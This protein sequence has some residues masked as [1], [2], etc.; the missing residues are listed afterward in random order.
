MSCKKVVRCLAVAGCVAAAGMAWAG[1]TRVDRGDA[2]DK[3]GATA[4]AQS[5][6]LRDALALI[7]ASLP[8]STALS[9]S[10]SGFLAAHDGASGDVVGLAFAEEVYRV[11]LFSRSQVIKSHI[12]LVQADLS[13]DAVV[14]RVRGETG[15][16]FI[17]TIL[18]RDHIAPIDGPGTCGAT[19][20]L[21]MGPG[22]VGDSRVFVTGVTGEDLEASLDR[23]FEVASPFLTVAEGTQL[24]EQMEGGAGGPQMLQN[25]RLRACQRACTATRDA[26]NAAAAAELA[27]CLATTQYGYVA[28][29][30]ACCFSG[31]WGYIPCA[32]ACVTARNIA[33]GTCNSNYTT[34]V[35]ANGAAW[36]ACMTACQVNNPPTPQPVP[37]T[38][39]T[40]VN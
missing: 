26:A 25:P 11:P 21:V 19:P 6:N 12:G 8:A 1:P 32:A 28:C 18:T 10:E 33:E 34:A 9:V 4:P 20:L 3:A 16:A 7:D 38:P 31:P 14:Y 40:P 13:A 35:T 30:G 22:G 29:L 24:A 5:S 36:T 37:I 2:G 15:E 27:N 39:I 23:A 17:S